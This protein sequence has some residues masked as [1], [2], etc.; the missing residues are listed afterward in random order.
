MATRKT[1]SAAGASPSGK[2][3][4]AANQNRTKVL[5]AAWDAYYGRFTKP[6]KIVHGVDDNVIVNRIRPIAD[7]A[8]AAL[9]GKD[10]EIK[11]GEKDKKSAQKYLDAVFK[12]NRKMTF[13]QKLGL[14]GAVAGHPFIKI[15]PENPPRLVALDPGTVDV[16]TDPDDIDTVS[17]YTIT[18]ATA[19]GPD[20]EQVQRRQL[21]TRDKGGKSW[22]IVDQEKD[23]GADASK[24]EQVGDVKKWD[25]AFAPI[26]DCQNITAPNQYYGLPDITDDL[27]QINRDINYILSNMARIIRFHGAPKTVGK[28]FKAEQLKIAVDGSIVLPDPTSDLKILEMSSDL[29]G[30][31]S[32]VEKLEAAMEILARIPAIALAALK[33]LP[34]GNVSGVAIELLLQPII[35]KT[36]AKQRNYGDMIEDLCMCLLEMGGYTASEIVITWPSILP[37]DQLANAQ[38][39]QLLLALGISKH[40]VYTLLGFDYDE[41]QA[42]KLEEAADSLANQQAAGITAGPQMSG[43]DMAGGAQNAQTAQGAANAAAPGSSGDGGP[44]NQ[45]TTS[46]ASIGRVAA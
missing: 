16:F 5:A 43:S 26:R 25:Y 1:A 11:V 19:S 30:A 42:L 17:A 34:R 4:G 24:W 27:I 45:N 12:K 21:I 3:Q 28:G 20:G 39:A 37:D 13:L 40:A 15:I 6:L 31:M 29:H 2:D 32:I 14:N 9:F 33:D 41:Q 22:T 44:A 10:V 23:P 18:Y 7:L 36:E 8:V 46:P 35:Q 38:Y